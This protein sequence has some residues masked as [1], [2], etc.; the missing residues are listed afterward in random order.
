MVTIETLPN[1]NL[2]IVADDQETRDWIAGKLESSNWGYSQI[3]CELVDGYS[4]NGS[5]TYFD[6][7]DGNPF[8]GLTS[9]PCIAESMNYSDNG[10]CEIEGRFWYFDNYQ[11]ESELSQIVETGK[12]EFTLAR[13][14]E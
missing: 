14:S 9:A 8:V 4:C 12:T 6:A 11:I 3:W 7:G 5:F 1:G 2:S 13:E 10:D